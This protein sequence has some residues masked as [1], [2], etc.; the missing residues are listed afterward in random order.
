MIFIK[1]NHFFLESRIFIKKKY[2]LTGGRIAHPYVKPL[3]HSSSLPL[4]KIP[5]SNEFF[6]FR[7]RIV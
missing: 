3:H 1:K 6:I 5:F 2:F 7:I 4:K